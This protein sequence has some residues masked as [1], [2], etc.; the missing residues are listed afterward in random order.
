[1]LFDQ[2]FF[3]D[4]YPDLAAL[5]EAG[6]VHSLP[7]LGGAWALTRHA[8]VW[9]LLRDSRLSARRAHTLAS[10]FSQTERDQLAPFFRL[11]NEW[12]LFF[13][14]PDHTRIRR[15][16][17][18]LLGA[19]AIS[20]WRRSI[21]SITDDLLDAVSEHGEM[22]VIADVANPLPAMVICAMLGLPEEDLSTLIGWSNDIARFFDGSA[23][24]FPVALKA[25]ASLLELTAYLQ[26]QV[27]SHAPGGDLITELK[28]LERQGCFSSRDQLIAQCAML[29]FAGHET[30]RNLIGNGTLALMRNPYQIRRLRAEPALYRTLADELLRYD[31]PV[32]LGTR[33]ALE[34][35]AVHDSV[36]PAG[37][38]VLFLFGSANR[39]PREFVNPDEIDIGRHPN[40]H[41]SFGS[42]MHSCLGAA[43]G[44]LECEVALQAMIAR[45]SD[46]HLSSENVR[47]QETFGFRG[48]ERLPVRFRARTA[49]AHGGSAA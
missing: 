24:G 15:P 33:I 37:S 1:M 3:Q 46:L 49:V 21:Q 7:M 5:R 41:V 4:P 6:A 12:M 13:D 19:E 22:D 45:F 30:T 36:I 44:R 35:T 47:W 29:L 9:Q 34:D 18:P 40:R 32:Q 20:R 48:L 14:P 11:F 31:S 26:S 39:D 43:L 28:H 42:G 16:M 17:A 10:T 27:D 25:Q 8:D 23:V 38:L 2:A